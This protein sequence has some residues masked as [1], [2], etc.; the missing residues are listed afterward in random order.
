VRYWNEN[1]SAIGI[2][3]VPQPPHDHRNT[4]SMRP[5]RTLLSVVLYPLPGTTTRHPNL[6]A[7]GGDASVGSERISKC[8]TLVG[9]L[10]YSGI[11]YLLPMWWGAIPL[12]LKQENE[13]SNPLDDGRPSL[14]GVF[15]LQRTRYLDRFLSKKTPIRPSPYSLSSPCDCW[16]PI[17]P[18]M[19][20]CL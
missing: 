18:N 13:R 14:H 11:A 16:F 6:A 2:R 4:C 9:R 15:D 5:L 3:I 12:N 17:K 8:V 10:S 1:Y 20:V 7:L 19:R